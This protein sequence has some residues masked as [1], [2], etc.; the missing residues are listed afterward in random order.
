MLHSVRTERAE[1]KEYREWWGGGGGADLSQQAAW[2]VW[3]R[4]NLVSERLA[5]VSSESSDPDTVGST[6]RYS[7]ILLSHNPIG[8]E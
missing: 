2:S 8:E 7:S 4:W 1:V 6:S 3:L 5:S